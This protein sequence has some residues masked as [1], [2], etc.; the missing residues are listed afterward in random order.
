LR[1]GNEATGGGELFVQRSFHRP[2]GE[3]IAGNWMTLTI[4]SGFLRSS[5]LDGKTSTQPSVRAATYLHK[6]IIRQVANM[7]SARSPLLYRALRKDLRR[8]LI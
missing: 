4:S 2:F 5:N 7:T 8:F 1:N 3:D 6:E